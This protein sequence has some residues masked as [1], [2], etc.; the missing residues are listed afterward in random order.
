[1]G[2]APAWDGTGCELVS[3]IPGSVGYIFHVYWTYDYLGPFGVLW[4][5]MAWHK[6]CVKNTAKLVE[7]TPAHSYRIIKQYNTVQYNYIRPWKRFH[8][9]ERD[10]RPSI[11]S[12]TLSPWSARQ[13]SCLEL[14]WTNWHDC[15]S[16]SQTSP[17]G[18]RVPRPGCIDLIR[19]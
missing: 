13:A 4:V 16:P 1:M 3:S 5:H 11:S 15:L 6:N 17:F 7:R 10:I 14:W 18:T 2:S 12:S 19:L 8:R 9:M